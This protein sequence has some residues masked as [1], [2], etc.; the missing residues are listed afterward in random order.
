MSACLL[1]AAVGA[2]A[3]GCRIDIIRFRTGNPID[4]RKYEDLRVDETTREAVMETLGAPDK[5]EHKSGDDYVWYL[6][7]DTVGTGVR[8]VFPPFR[9]LFG[10]QHT[11]LRLDENSE[12]VNALG[13]VFDEA[14]ILR[15]K[16]LR[17]SES[18]GAS[19][20]AKPPLR[21]TMAPYG[22]YS[23]LLLGDGG[24][25]DYDALFDRGYKA[26]LDVGL[27]PFPILQFMVGANVQRYAGRTVRYTE[28]TVPPPG[29]PQPVGR[30]ARP[31]DLE[32]VQAR[33]GF[34][35]E[36]PFEVFLRLGDFEALKR[37]LFEA[38]PR[39]G[40]GFRLYIQGTTGVSF[41]PEIGVRID[42]ADAGALYERGYG[43][44][45]DAGAGVEF[46]WGWGSA[47]V[48]AGY[49][50]VGSFRDGDSRLDGDGEALEALMV[51]GGVSL[52]F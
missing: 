33:V 13:L 42:G 8:F 46:A 25:G 10:Y 37:I 16:N 9:S 24:F 4:E 49:Q 30:T 14:G 12:E 26:G 22:E 43:F 20:D 5:V 38:D 17:L 31:D 44:S 34:R 32:I 7:A 40:R 6:Y 29:P 51:G 39:K 41:H 15:T 18:Y 52:R 11:F 23:A 28:E 35:I 21:V 50:S 45:G 47:Y 1:C 27:E 3:S 48:G 19:D 36:I 2:L